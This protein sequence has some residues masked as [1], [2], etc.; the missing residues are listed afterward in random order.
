[1]KVYRYINIKLNVAINMHYIKY[2]QRKGK[3]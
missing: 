3:S 2:V 1:M